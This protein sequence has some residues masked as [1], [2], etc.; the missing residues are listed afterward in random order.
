MTVFDQRGQ[1]VTTQYNINMGAVQSAPDLVAELKK[2][3]AQLDALTEDGKLGEN[4]IDAETNVKKAAREAQQAVPDKKKIGDYLTTAKTA[5]EG[6]AAASGLVVAI[7][8]AIEL[9]EKL[10]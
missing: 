9:V 8:K 3:Q 10:F 6:V 5:I 2:V 7:T 4:G 1:K